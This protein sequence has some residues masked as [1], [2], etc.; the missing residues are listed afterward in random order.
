VG[1]DSSE[2]PQGC[3]NVDSVFPEAAPEGKKDVNLIRS[4]RYR[5]E[6]LE[7]LERFER[8]FSS[9]MRAVR[10]RDD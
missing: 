4:L 5:L 6:R 3:L 8:S 10:D 1:R 2:M 7:L 9:E